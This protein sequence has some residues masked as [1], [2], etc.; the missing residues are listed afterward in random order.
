MRFMFS[1]TIS[2]EA[3]KNAAMWEMKWHLLILGVHPQNAQAVSYLVWLVCRFACGQSFGKGVGHIDG[4]GIVVRGNTCD[5]FADKLWNKRSHLGK[6]LWGACTGGKFQLWCYLAGWWRWQ[7][8]Q[9][10]LTKSTSSSSSDNG[11]G[12]VAAR[13]NGKSPRGQ[14]WGPPGTLLRV[15][16]LYRGLAM[17]TLDHMICYA[18]WL[19]H[20]L[21][22]RTTDVS[23]QPCNG[24]EANHEDRVR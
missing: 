18:T 6:T 3:A 17:C 5:E 21:Y 15:Y 16:I 11:S 4:M 23:V 14:D 7:L 20:E 10:T 2:S 9:P 1:L 22:M 13:D 24:R 12:L 8:K 19:V